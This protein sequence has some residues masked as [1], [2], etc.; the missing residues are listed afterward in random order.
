MNDG[1]R[2]I[3]AHPERY[4]RIERK[5]GVIARWREVGAYLQVNHGSLSGR[6]GAAAKGFLPSLFSQG[7]AQEASILMH[8]EV[9]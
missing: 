3:I 8:Y 5:L 9:C 4:I 6:Y 2:P 1:Y 7:G